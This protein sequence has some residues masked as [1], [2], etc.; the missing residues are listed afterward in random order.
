MNTE[1]L[2]AIVKSRFMYQ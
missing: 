2:S 1:E